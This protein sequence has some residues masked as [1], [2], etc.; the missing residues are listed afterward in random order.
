MTDPERVEK[1]LQC[2]EKVLSYCAGQ[3]YDTFSA[4]SMLVEAC[5]FNI[6]QIG[7]ICHGVSDAFMEANP[8]IPWFEMY[9]LRNRIVHNYDGVKLHLVWDIIAGDLEILQKDLQKIL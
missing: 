4:N 7:E 3:T 8:E 1:M 5:V 2:V 6:S 9:G